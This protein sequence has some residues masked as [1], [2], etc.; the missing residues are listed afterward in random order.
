MIKS[1]KMKKEILRILDETKDLVKDGCIVVARDNL[2]QLVQLL[3][4]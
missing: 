3:T 2:V 1:E 4:D